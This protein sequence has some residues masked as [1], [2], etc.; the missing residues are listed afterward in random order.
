[1]SHELIKSNGRY[2]SLAL[3]G[4]YKNENEYQLL[5]KDKYFNLKHLRTLLTLF[6]LH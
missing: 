5:I 4:K 1:M 6:Q 2:I 3:F